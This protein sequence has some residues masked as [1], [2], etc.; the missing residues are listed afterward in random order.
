MIEGL[1]KECA[2][3]N[4]RLDDGL[5]ALNDL[6]QRVGQDS[7]EFERSFVEWLNQKDDYESA[8]DQLTVLETR[9]ELTEWLATLPAPGAP[10]KSKNRKEQN[11]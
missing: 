7:P 2:E 10:V 3:L 5:D 8:C 4:R 6:A 9:V 1:R 11:E